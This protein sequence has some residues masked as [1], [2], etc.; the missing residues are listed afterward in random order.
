MIF[1]VPVQN[2]VLADLIFPHLRPEWFSSIEVRDWVV[3]INATRTG[4]SFSDFGPKIHYLVWEFVDFLSASSN[5]L[6]W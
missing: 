5:I 1:D 2:V 6:V 3:I 4:R